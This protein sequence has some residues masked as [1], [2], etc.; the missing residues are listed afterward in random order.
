MLQQNQHHK[1][2]SNNRTIRVCESCERG[3]RPTI[4]ASRSPNISRNTTDILNFRRIFQYK[5]LIN[6]VELCFNLKCLIVFIILSSFC[7]R[8]GCDD[9]ENFQKNSK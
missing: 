3:L 2:K 7:T 9:T 1:C 8:T 6:I 5:S 4:T